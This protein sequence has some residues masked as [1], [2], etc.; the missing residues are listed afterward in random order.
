MG[1]QFVVAEFVS[2]VVLMEAFGPI[3]AFEPVR[4]SESG[5]SAV[6]DSDVPGPLSLDGWRTAAARF[7]MDWSMI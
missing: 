6:D 3:A 7:A 2:G 4:A 5:D 1:R